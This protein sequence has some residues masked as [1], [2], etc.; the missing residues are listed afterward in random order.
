MS[1]AGL[2][3]RP[4]KVFYG[5]W[6][7]LSGLI[8]NFLSGA[9]Y[10]YGFSAFFSPISNELGWKRAVMSAPL[11][12]SKLEGAL[13]G[14]LAGYMVDKFGPRKLMFIGVILVGTGYLILSRINS[15]A[16]FYLV[17]IFFYALGAGLVTTSQQVAVVNWFRKRRALALGILLGGFNVGAMATPAVVWLIA[18]RGW[19]SAA[20]IIGSIMLMVQIPLSRVLRHRP[21]SYG[22]LPDGMTEEKTKEIETSSRKESTVAEHNFTPIQAVRTQ[23]FWFISLAYACRNM[24]TAA[25][26]V[27]LIPFIQDLGY[28]AAVGG[29]MMAIMGASAL[30]GRIV[31]GHLADIFP[32]RYAF[33]SCMIVLGISVFILSSAQSVW[34][35]VLWAVL[36]GPAYGVGAPIMSATI[37]D[38]Y[39][40][41]FFGTINGLTHIAMALT[42]V[43][44]PVFAGYMFDVT[45]SYR[46]AFVS[47]AAVC[48]I[49]AMSAALARRPQPAAAIST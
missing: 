34:Q 23:S 49:G 4:K 36:Y 19:R 46:L 43:V 18:A 41:K 40:R 16:M 25:V 35:L 15:L 22:Y 21:E 12:L 42:T 10:T 6:I 2:L 30:I 31:M 1:T 5:W 48:A 28:S 27:H 24:I 33:A 20:L 37:A 17:F 44:G 45:G 32:K 26:P 14:P 29:N 38:Y 3:K 11:G 39:G 8:A 47:F 7:V 9:M 13:F